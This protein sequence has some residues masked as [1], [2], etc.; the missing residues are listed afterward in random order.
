MLGGHLRALRFGL[1][2]RWRVRLQR[3]QCQQP[4]GRL[5]DAGQLTWNH[6]PVVEGIPRLAATGQAHPRRFRAD[7]ARR[8]SHVDTGRQL[9]V[10]D[11]GRVKPFGQRQQQVSRLPTARGALHQRARK[12]FVHRLDACQRIGADRAAR[13]VVQVQ[14]QQTGRA[15]IDSHSGAGGQLEPSANYFGVGGCVQKSARHQCARWSLL[16]RRKRQHGPAHRS[17]GQRMGQ[18]V[19]L[20][21]AHECAHDSGRTVAAAA[22]RMTSVRISA[23]APGAQTA[24][25]P[26]GLTRGHRPALRRARR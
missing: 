11:A 12:L 18:A 17:I 3:Q 2:R 25:R 23:P 14:H 24:P 15:G 21:G 19:R 9:G 1:V 8:T 22:A 7:V 16:T 20:G 6:V 5:S 4:I 10:S 26:A 13:L